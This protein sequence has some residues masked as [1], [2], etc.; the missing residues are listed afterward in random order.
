M[1]KRYELD[2]QK[3]YRADGHRATGR[4]SFAIRKYSKPWGGKKVHR[5]AYST[6]GKR[7]SW[8]KKYDSLDAAK[9]AA[10]RKLKK[11]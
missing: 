4:G 2:W 8:S 10:Q 9:K 1:A 5:Y 3:E 7:E 6:S 11:K